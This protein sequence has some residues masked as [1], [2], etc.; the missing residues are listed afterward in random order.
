MRGAVDLDERPL[1]ALAVVVQRVGDELL[2]GTVLA[3][4]EDVRVAAR[5]ALDELEHLVH[6]L[7][8]A[9]DV[10]EAELALE[11]LLE[12]LVLA[13]QLAALDRALEHRQQRVGL[14]RLLDEAVRAGLHRLDRLGHAAV[15]GDD[16]D[17]GRGMRLLEPAQ[18]LQPVRV[19]QHHVGDDDVGLPGAEDLVAAGPDHRCPD[20]VALVLEQDFQPLD[21]RRLVVYGEDTA[22]LLRSGSSEQ[23]PV[24]AIAAIYGA[25]TKEHQK[26]YTY[27]Q[28]CPQVDICHAFIQLYG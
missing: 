13:Y 25:V 18:Q 10:A 26:V 27:R 22:L 24:G 16:D 1:G 9:D 23:S 20:L 4:H 17:F 2:A 28:K 8:L 3:L 5:D 12:Q 19:G 15:A 14:D 6:L 21:H 11:L 7:A